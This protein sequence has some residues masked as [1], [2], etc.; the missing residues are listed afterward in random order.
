FR[1]TVQLFELFP[2]LVAIRA[3]R[4]QLTE[5]K[6]VDVTVVRLDVI[7]NRGRNRT[8]GFAQK[9]RAQRLDPQLGFGNPSPPT[10]ATPAHQTPPSADKSRFRAAD[11]GP[12]QV[13][14]KGPTAG[15]NA[16]WKHQPAS[17]SQYEAPQL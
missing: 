3:Q 9:H 14:S 16:A 6:L 2:T 11:R 4:L 7:G 10:G 15:A 13:P 12:K 1:I 5:P 17:T 8:S